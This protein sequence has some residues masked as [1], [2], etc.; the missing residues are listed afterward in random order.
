M[1]DQVV[2]LKA[3][4]IEQIGEPAD[5]Y[6]TP[7]TTFAARFLGM[8]P[9]NV[10]EISEISNDAPIRKLVPEDTDSALIGVRPEKVILAEEGLP[11]EVSSVDFMGAETVLRLNHGNQSLMIRLDGRPVAKPGDKLNVAWQPSDMHFFT[12][13]GIRR[14][15]M[16]TKPSAPATKVQ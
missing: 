2:L 5:L 10:M 4:Q 14:N 11:V 6:E 15:G 16:T 3:G 7:E 12:E 13:N 1:A 9:M 8:P